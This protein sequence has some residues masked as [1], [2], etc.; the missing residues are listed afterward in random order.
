MRPE[1]INGLQR[2]GTLSIFDGR[3]DLGNT[4]PGDGAKYKGRGLIHLTGKANYADIGARLNVDLVKYP[5]LLEDDPKLAVASA[6]EWWNRQ[7]ERFPK[8]KEA[9]ETDNIVAVNRGVNGGNNGMTER[10]K[11]YNEFKKQLGADE[12]TSTASAQG[13]MFQQALKG[14]F[15]GT[16]G[17][18][19]VNAPQTVAAGT[20]DVRSGYNSS[21]GYQSVPA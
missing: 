8:F 21:S 2:W 5:Q 9:I 11:Y 19:G 20:A 15:S 17:I 12:P 7:K 4:A 3:K 14:D 18:D 16:K 6:L 1:I 10:I 13:E